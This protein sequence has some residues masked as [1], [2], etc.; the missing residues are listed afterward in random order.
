MKPPS[1]EPVQIVEKITAN[2]E[3]KEPCFRLKQAPEK[4]VLTGVKYILS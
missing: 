1:W 3:E 4:L 2:E